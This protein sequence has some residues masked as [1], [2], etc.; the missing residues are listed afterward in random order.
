[1]SADRFSRVCVTHACRLVEDPVRDL[2]TCPAC[3]R[4]ASR[5][6]V[7]EV[8]TGERFALAT[9]LEGAVAVAESAADFDPEAWL[10]DLIA[11][12]YGR[13]RHVPD[14]APPGA[15]APSTWRYLVGG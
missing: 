13:D 11:R 2:I 5:W 3:G 7:V 1:M 8:T 4:E 14:L 15:T 12:E 9:R 10:H 6:F